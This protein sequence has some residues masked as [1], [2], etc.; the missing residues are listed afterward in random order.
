MS[1]QLILPTIGITGTPVIDVAAGTLYVVAK[2]KN[3]S[4]FIQRLHALDI[5]SGAE[6][7]NSPVVIQCSVPGT[8]LGTDGLGH[9]P[10]NP[11]TQNQRPG[12]LLLNG[13]VS[14]SWA[15]HGDQDPYHGWVLGYNENTLQQ[16][17]VHN[18]N[19]NGTR[20]GIWQAGQGPA[21]D[22]KRQHFLY[23]RQRNIRWNHEQRLWR[24]HPQT[25]HD[26]LRH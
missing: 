18:T 3:G 1:T 11:L 24:Q 25:F 19:P 7:P 16:V 23:D 6:R 5:T 10:F 14:I 8:G 12:L 17:K 2:S 13:V 9:V 20:A 26:Q 21:A 15:S 22:T 4:T